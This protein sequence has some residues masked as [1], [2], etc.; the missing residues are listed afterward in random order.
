MRNPRWWRPTTSTH[1]WSSGFAGSSP[2]SIPH[3]CRVLQREQ[4][5]TRLG[6]WGCLLKES[7]IMSQGL[8][9]QALALELR[10]TGSTCLTASLTMHFCP[11]QSISRSSAQLL[12][13]ALNTAPLERHLHIIWITRWPIFKS[14]II[15]GSLNSDVPECTCSSPV[16]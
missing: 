10:S 4:L 6:S 8:G 5:R 7:T 14:S 13:N 1:R 16:S 12:M 9:H 3:S 2:H 11:P 15:F